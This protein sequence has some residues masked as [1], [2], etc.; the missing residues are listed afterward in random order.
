MRCYLLAFFM[1]AALLFAVTWHNVAPEEWRWLA[2]E[3]VRSCAHA[4]GGAIAGYA[5]A[6]WLA[7]KIERNSRR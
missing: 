6:L 2:E 4:A 7:W 3:E 5:L 1:I